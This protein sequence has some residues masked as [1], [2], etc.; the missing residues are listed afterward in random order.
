[1]FSLALRFAP[2]DN[3]KALIKRWIEEQDAMAD[4]LDVTDSVNLSEVSYIGAVDISFFPSGDRGI[5]A[6]AVERDGVIIYENYE[7][8]SFNVPYV[9]GFLGFREVPCY[10]SLLEKLKQEHPD[11]FPQILLVDGNGIL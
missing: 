11:I 10:I 5:S 2:G 4:K 6:L 7:H 1:M 3:K 8:V 9:S